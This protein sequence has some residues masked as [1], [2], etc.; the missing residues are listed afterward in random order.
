MLS[1]FLLFLLILHAMKLL[2]ILIVLTFPA[3]SL[4][5]PA[6]YHGD[7]IDDCLRLVP[8]VSAYALKA[9]GVRSASSWRRLLANTAASYALTLGVTGG[10][11]YAVHDMR[12]DR[13]DNKSFPSGHTSAAFAGAA[14]LHKE[15]HKVSPWISVAGYGVAAAT[16]IDRVRRNRHEWDDVFAGAAIGM[17][18]TEAG[19]RLGDLL[20]GERSRYSVA[21][22][23]EGVALTINL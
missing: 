15:F 4:A 9:A 8:V 23:P 2:L 14:I 12:P 3:R 10:L 16:A 19:Y 1:S 7:G 11:K 21:V 17:L 6:R 20:T 13:T 5:Q 18:A 22:G